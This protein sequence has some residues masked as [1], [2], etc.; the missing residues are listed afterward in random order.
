MSSSP[1]S[2]VS[3]DHHSKEW[4]D[5]RHAAYASLRAECPVAHNSRYG[6]FWIVSG[7]EEVN[8]VSRDGETFTSRYSPEPE[9]G[10]QLIGI[11]G[12]PRIKGVPPAGIAEVDGPVHQAL[13]RTIN[14]RVLPAAVAAMQ[15]LME[16]VARW[17]LDQKI[18][19]GAMDMVLDYTNPVPAVLTMELLGLPKDKWEYYADMFHTTVALQPS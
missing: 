10:I 8:A 16:Q 13:R 11:T 15:P 17:F 7:Y 4:L 2:D 14:P 9:D 3:F 5:D 6:G 12:V 18:E 1:M 19:D